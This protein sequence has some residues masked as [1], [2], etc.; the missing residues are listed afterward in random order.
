MLNDS[1]VVIRRNPLLCAGLGTVLYAAP[2]FALLLWYFKA[3]VGSGKT[4]LW[5]FF[6]EHVMLAIAGVLDYVGAIAI[7][8]DSLMRVAIVDMHGEKP[9]TT[10]CLGVALALFF[11]ILL[12]AL[13]TTVAMTLG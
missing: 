13:V 5:V 9:S 10:D 1:F 6:G 7:S 3:A 2:R 11:P 8:P 4:P 12:T